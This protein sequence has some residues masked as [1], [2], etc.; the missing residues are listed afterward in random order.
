MHL[1]QALD[2][3]SESVRLGRLSGKALVLQLTKQMESAS[4]VEQR[5]P[6]TIVSVQ[7]DQPETGGC[8]GAS[9]RSCS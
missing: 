9:S 7:Q 1:E 4:E 8:G 2:Y 5:L 6:T 3:A